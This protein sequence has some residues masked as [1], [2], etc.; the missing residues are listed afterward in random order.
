[1]DRRVFPDG[2]LWGVATSAFQIEGAPEA[3]GRGE[4]IWD[5][6]AATPGRIA[7]G[8]DGA[9]ACDHYHRWRD[10]ISLLKRLGVGAYRFSISWPRILPRGRGTLNVRGLDVLEVGC[11]NGYGAHLLSGQEPA[12]YLGADLMPEQI[13]LARRHGPEG[14]DFVVMDATNLEGIPSQSRDVVVVFGILHHIPGWLEAL[15]EVRRVLRPGGLFFF[16]EPDHLFIDLWDRCLAW[17]HHPDAGFRLPTLEATVTELGFLLEDR[18]VLPR[19]LGSYRARKITTAG[20]RL[21]TP[22]D[23]RQNSDA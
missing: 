20:P 15:A 5:R 19:A 6:F 10:D 1:M 12:S 7:D 22:L 4:S 11:G 3:D 9:V 14:Y 2:F 21:V 13:T 17:G 23:P 8:S 16:E 18:V